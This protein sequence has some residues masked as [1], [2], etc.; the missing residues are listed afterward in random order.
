MRCTISLIFLLI[1]VNNLK[2]LPFGVK[3]GD[4][5]RS[6]NQQQQKRIIIRKKE[7]AD[8]ESRR[9]S[10]KAILNDSDVLNINDDNEESILE[11]EKIED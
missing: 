2:T 4:N 9:N 11:L 5:D 6:N 10:D 8:E 1:L 7:K 3:A